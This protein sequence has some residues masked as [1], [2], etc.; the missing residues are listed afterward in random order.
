[1]RSGAQAACRGT[2]MR[3]TATGAL[4]VVFASSSKVF[5]KALGVAAVKPIALRQ[6]PA[7]STTFT[8][9]PI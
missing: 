3:A 4:S 2:S 7:H 9:L 1:M 6:L 5:R 8:S